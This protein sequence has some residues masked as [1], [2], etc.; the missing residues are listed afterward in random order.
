MNIPAT[1]REAFYMTK[2]KL[3]GNWDKYFT[4]EKGERYYRDFWRPMSEDFIAH[5]GQ[6][7]FSKVKVKGKE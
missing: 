3:L 7:M 1:P 4:R 6:A 2:E 5:E